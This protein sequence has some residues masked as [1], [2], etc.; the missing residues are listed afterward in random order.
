[1]DQRWFQRKGWIA[2]LMPHTALRGI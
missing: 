1:V 2:R